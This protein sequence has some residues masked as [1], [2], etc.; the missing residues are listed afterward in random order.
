[1]LQINS[2]WRS[3]RVFEHNVKSSIITVQPNSRL[4][5][6]RTWAKCCFCYSHTFYINRHCL[7][8]FIICS[9]NFDLSKVSTS[10]DSK[11]QKTLK[12]HCAVTLSIINCIKFNESNNQNRFVQQIARNWRQCETPVF[13]PFLNVLSSST[14][15]QESELHIVSALMQKAFTHNASDIRGAVK[16]L[17]R[18]A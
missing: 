17:D 8:S 15:L 9:C 13:R 7:Q 12:T 14:C 5:N 4:R 11:N 1:M 2:Q 6:P 3:V 18:R 10:D 16:K